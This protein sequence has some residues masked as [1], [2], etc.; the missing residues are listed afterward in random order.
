MIRKYNGDI[1]ID[2]RF[3]CSKSET[4]ADLK[5][6][7]LRDKNAEYAIEE[8]E[9]A[10]K[11]LKAYREELNARAQELM[12]MK[13]SKRITLRRERDYYGNRVYYRLI[14]EEVYEDGSDHEISRTTY[15]GTERHKAISEFNK[16]K[17][18][19][20][21]FEFVLNISKGRWEK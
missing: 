15:E 10:L 6:L 20:P 19:Y 9:A 5:Q 16:M 21:Q 1:Q 17:K 18:Q 14:T 3:Y 12:L 11:V 2:L 8:C 4:V 7:Q 13:S